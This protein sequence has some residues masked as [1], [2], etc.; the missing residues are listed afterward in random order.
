MFASYKNKNLTNFL[1]KFLQFYPKNLPLSMTKDIININNIINYGI[2][3]VICV[4]CCYLLYYYTIN[5][6][7]IFNTIKN[8]CRIDLH[9][10]NFCFVY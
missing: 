10:L 4:L 6:Y 9:F 3:Y 8:I 7:G 5:L 1:I 2:Y